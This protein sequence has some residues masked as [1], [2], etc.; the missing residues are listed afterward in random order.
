LGAAPRAGAGVAGGRLDPD[1]GE[2][3]AIPDP[4]IHDAVEGDATGE[5]EAIGVCGF[6]QA[7]GQSVVVDANG[8]V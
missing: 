5:A 3:T 6:A 8:S 1:T 2:L 4:R 7:G